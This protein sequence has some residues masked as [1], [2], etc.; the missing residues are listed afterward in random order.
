MGGGSQ[1]VDVDGLRIAYE[2]AGDGPPLVLAHG[3]FGD[4]REW[5]PQLD[6]LSDAFTVVAWDAPGCGRSDDPPDAFFMA[7]FADCLAGFIDAL[8]LVEPHVGGLSFGGALALGF[9]E[10]H[11]QT[12][13]S[14]I[15]MS[16]YAG[17]AGSLPP[18]VVA[19]R[20]RIF[21]TYLTRPP[22]E[23]AR[24]F[25]EQLFTGDVPPSVAEEAIAMMAEFRPAGLRA[26]ADALAG[27]DLRDVLPRIDVPVLM[28]YGEEDVRSPPAVAEAIHAA[29]PHA[30]L[31]LLAG[32]GHQCNLEVADRVNAEIRA[33]LS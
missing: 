8:G 29:I 30:E 31:V 16:A 22:E 2:I 23:I 10:R 6:G 18:E 12:P 14:L 25:A 17:W 15:L 11:P 3:A 26:M 21:E 9:F 27:A 13:A 7:D 33:F 1:Q 20:V 32:A 24:E 5:R 4:S 28:L 19:E